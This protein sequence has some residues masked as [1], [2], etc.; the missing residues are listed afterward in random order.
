MLQISICAVTISWQ[1]LSWL[2]HETEK[3]S[4]NECLCFFTKQRDISYFWCWKTV[5]TKNV[6][7][8]TFWIFLSNQCLL[9]TDEC[10]S[11]WTDHQV[12]RTHAHFTSDNLRPV[13]TRTS[14]HWV[15][16][17][18]A[19]HLQTQCFRSQKYLFKHHIFQT[20][21]VLKLWLDYE[22]KMVKETHLWKT[23][24]S[25]LLIKWPLNDHLYF[26]RL[27]TQ[28]I[29]LCWSITWLTI[30]DVIVHLLSCVCPSSSVPGS[31]QGSCHDEAGK[32]TR[33]PEKP[34]SKTGKKP[35]CDMHHYWLCPQARP[36]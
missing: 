20:A 11:Q 10:K 6:Y 7:P 3:T 12:V 23:M 32:L 29:K 27:L 26:L 16:P 34:K 13:H 17:Y 14:F 35:R 31:F 1:P 8:A 5:W 18:F 9:N 28:P 36:Q 25:T 30:L 33:P 19:H 4:W 21:E 15:A 22:V 24:A 2:K